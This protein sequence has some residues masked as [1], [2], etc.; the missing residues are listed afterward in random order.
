M[1][2]A[3]WGAAYTRTIVAFLERL[4]AQPPL[5]L[6]LVERLATTYGL[7]GNRNSEVRLQWQLLALKA[8]YTAV[9]PDVVAFATSQ[10]RMKYVR[11]LYRYDRLRRR[12]WEGGRMQRR[13]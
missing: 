13:R 8:Q 2:H 12:R 4:L 6:A 3:C 11:P 7:A 1:V 5:P 10:G 9:L